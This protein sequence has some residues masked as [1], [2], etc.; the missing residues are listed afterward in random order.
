[1]S[2]TTKNPTEVWKAVGIE[3]NIVA[4]QNG[5]CEMQKLDFDTDLDERNPTLFYSKTE[6]SGHF[7]LLIPRNVAAANKIPTNGSKYIANR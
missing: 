2:F 1:L 5:T 7:D 3:F 4:L 6:G